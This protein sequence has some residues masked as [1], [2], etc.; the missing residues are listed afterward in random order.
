MRN[1]SRNRKDLNHQEI[2]QAFKDLGFV[3]FD[4]SNLPNCCDLM[5]TKKG[6][7]IAIEIKDGSLCKS[8][9]VLTLGEKKFAQS[10]SVQGHW[11]LVES[12]ED[13]KK[14]NE[15]VIARVKK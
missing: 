14:I 3:V 1:Y 8:K 6:I 7:T 9:R 5:V 4:V 2:V 15:E 11:E 10:W 12:V 13:V